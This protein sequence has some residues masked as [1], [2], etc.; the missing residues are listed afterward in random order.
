ME[1]NLKKELE[2][3]GYIKINNSNL[4]D[5]DLIEL[6]KKLGKPV[7]SRMGGSLIDRLSP[8]RKVDS[9]R[10][11]LSNVHQLNSFPLHSDTAYYK[12]PVKYI[13]LYCKNPGTG[14][15]PTYLYDTHK[16]IYKYDELRLKLANVIFKVI[17]GRN[18]FLT[19][20][21]NPE[22]DFFRLDRDCMRFISPEGEDLFKEVDNLIHKEDIEEINWNTN[23]LLIIDNWRYLHGRGRSKTKDYERLLYRLSIRES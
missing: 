23:D 13:L 7:E 1:F 20:I 21:Y 6:S 10:N 16:L 22:I 19:T 3:V 8:K 2:E 14:G 18:S 4:G 9:N 12:I 15:R 5:T 17:N 11:S